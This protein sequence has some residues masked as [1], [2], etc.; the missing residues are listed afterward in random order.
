MNSK[1]D[2]YFKKFSKFPST[3]SDYP[4]PGP[5]D[6][7]FQRCSPEANRFDRSAAPLML[8]DTILIFA[9]V[10]AQKLILPY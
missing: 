6:D 4:F 1:G 7:S 10:E 2:A 3:L 9:T 5:N 8:M